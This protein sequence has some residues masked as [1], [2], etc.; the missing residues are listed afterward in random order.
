MR[1]AIYTRKSVA[2]EFSESINTQIDL[3]KS[4]FNGEHI[5]EIFEDEGFSGGNTNRPAFKK[6]MNLCKLSK[7]DIVAVYKVDRISRNIIDFVN[8]Y[9]ELKVN[10][11]KLV[12][13]TEGFDTQTAMGE[14]MM[15]I[16]SAFAN[17]ERENIRQRVKDNMIALAKKGCFTGGFV[18]FGCQVEK[19]DGKSYLKI[20]DTDLIKLMFNKYLELGSLYALQS[21]LTNNGLKTLTTRSSL[22]K[23]LRN[24]VY[25]ESDSKISKYFED[26]GY[27]V[28]GKPNKKG[29]MTYGK[30]SDYSTLI[31]GKHN[32]VIDS[33]TFLKVNLLLDKNKDTANKKKSKTYWLTETLYCPFCN[34]KYVLVNSGRNTYYVCSN[35]LNRAKTELG[36]DTEKE[37]CINSK[38]I[39][40]VEIELKVTKLV[41]KLDN[42]KYFNELYTTDINTSSDKEIE[43]KVLEKSILD[44]ERSINNLVDKL[45]LLSNTGAIPITK[46]IETLTLKN[47]ELKSKLEDL[48]LLQIENIS[49]QNKEEVQKNISTFNS[50]KNNK[51]KRI[52][53]RK[54]FEKLI[55]NPMDDSIKLRF[56]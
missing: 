33:D 4:Y 2:I 8:I 48:K 49:K 31:V 12:S 13:I 54:I 47:E 9:N 55:Y 18:P 35:R 40:A 50:L 27:E 21:Y 28:V 44:N 25:C 46:K 16:L 32:A 5:F 6:M 34:S 38:Y 10:N 51:D 15:F 29:Y 30:T 37:K 39:N 7:F 1:I 19:I 41:H 45:M 14:M 17:M 43:I 26:K 11:V 23:L 56:K 53:I 24:P 20:S 52:C 42:E 36:L 3:C 22:G